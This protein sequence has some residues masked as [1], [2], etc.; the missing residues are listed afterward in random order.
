MAVVVVVVVEC[1]VSKTV[2]QSLFSPMGN[3]LVCMAEP[4]WAAVAIIL[5]LSPSAGRA[6]YPAAMKG[7]R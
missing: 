5:T 4:A 2:V 1:C 6:V 7:E 3:T